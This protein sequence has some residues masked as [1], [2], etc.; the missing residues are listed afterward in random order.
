MGKLYSKPTILG[1]IGALILW[2]QAVSSS[3]VADKPNIIFLLAD[4]LRYDAVGYEKKWQISTPAIDKLADE[5]TVFKNTY[6]TSSICCARR[7]SIFTGQYVRRHGIAGFDTDIKGDD[8]QNTYPLLLKNS[9]YRIGFIGKYGVGNYLPKEHFDY[10][11]GFGGQG[12]YYHK[13]NEGRDIHL[14]A[15]ISGQIDEFLE[16]GDKSKPFCLSV[17]FK[18]PHTESEQDPFPYDGRYEE[19]YK[20]NVFPKPES[21]GEFYYMKFPEAFRREGKWENEGHVRFRNRFE[22]DDKF[23]TSVKG[24]F[25]LIAGIDNTIAKLRKKLG[26]LGLAGNTIIIFTSDNGYYLGEHGL[27]GKWYG[28]E[29]SIRLPLVIYDPRLKEHAHTT[30]KIALNIDFPVTMLDYAGSPVPERMQGKSLRPLVEKSRT[31]WRDCFLYEHLL[32]LD[33]QGWYVYIPQNEGVVTHHYKYMRYFNDNDSKHPVYEELFD[34]QKDPEELKNLVAGDRHKTN[35]LRTKLE[36][37]ILQ[38]E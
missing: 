20:N 11:K 38:A 14:T 6:A 13:D 28:H 25:S 17:S 22:T 35:E 5:G 1:I 27:E 34:T 9:G 18:S 7:A 4:D 19:F 3:P 26:E 8:L 33:K 32:N 2:N 15:Q 21:F 29:E 37:L 10:W 31:V 23:Q 12:T 36:R 24:Y 30:E 16:T